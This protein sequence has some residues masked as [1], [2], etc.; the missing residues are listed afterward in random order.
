MKI[1]CIFGV[2]YGQVLGDV[3]GMFFEFW[4]CSCVKVYF[5]WI[6]CFLSGLKENNVVCY[7]NCVE[8]I[9]D[10]LMVLCLVDVLLECEGKIELDLIGCNIFDWVLCF[11]VFN[12]NVLGLILKIVFNVICDGKFVVELENNGV[13]NGVVMC[14][15]LLGCLFLVCDVDFFI[16]DVVLVLSLIYKFDLV[17]VGVV[18]IVWVIFCVIDGESWLVIVDFLFLIV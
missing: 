5:G 4:L 10:I 1:E 13:I 18:V 11:D 14:V 7:F 3:M 6:D 15:L 9:D 16:D 12:K 2:F 8:F 17:V